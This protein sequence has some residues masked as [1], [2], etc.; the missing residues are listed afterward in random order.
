MT[1]AT[2]RSMTQPKSALLPFGGSSGPVPDTHPDGGVVVKIRRNA[3]VKRK[4]PGL[5]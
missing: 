2:L 5:P 1:P 3:Y 4:P